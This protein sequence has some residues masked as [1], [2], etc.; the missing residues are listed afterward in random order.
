[1]RF[2]VSR[3]IDIMNRNQNGSNALHIAVKKDNF[4][5]IQSLIDMH[6]PL[7]Y[8][9]NNGVT[10]VGIACYKGS[11]QLIDI[12]YKAGA[13]IN[14]KSMSGVNSLYLAVKGNHL[15]CV[16]YLIERKAHYHLDDHVQSE[17]SPLFQAIR[18][19]SQAIVEM[20][21]D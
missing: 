17:Y 7:D 6:Y 12:L 2:L 20:I 15:E 13:D 18:Q 11:V 8:T 1:M 14:F 10:A 4:K 9:K 3:G 16:R 19:N 5:V 21:C